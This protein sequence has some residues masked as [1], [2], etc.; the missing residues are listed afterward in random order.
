MFKNAE[1]VFLEEGAALTL[2]ELHPGS[3][4]SSAIPLEI[5]EAQDRLQCCVFAPSHSRPS[6]G[7]QHAPAAGEPTPTPRLQPREWVL[8]PSDVTVWNLAPT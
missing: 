6:V 2:V 3:Q 5:E 1:E 8:M 4:K 7:P